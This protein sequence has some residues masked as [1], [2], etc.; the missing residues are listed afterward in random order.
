MEVS[1][2]VELSESP[3]YFSLKENDAKAFISLNRDYIMLTLAANGKAELYFHA[4][5]WTTFA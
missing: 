4:Y 5:M 2:Q 3:F 1:E